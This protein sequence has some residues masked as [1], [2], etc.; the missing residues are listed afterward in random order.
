MSIVAIYGP[1]ASGKL[2]T[3]KEV[4]EHLG[5]ALFDNHAVNDVLAPIFPYTNPTLNEYRMSLSRQFRYDVFEAAL[6]S[7][8][9]MVITFNYGG[10]GGLNLCRKL[11]EL[12]TTYDEPVYFVHLV[13]KKVA[14]YE[15]VVNPS[16][17]NKANSKERLDELLQAEGY[18]YDT[19]PDVEHLQLDNTDITPTESVEK[20]KEYYR[21]DS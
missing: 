11:V 8:A 12:S 13:P 1:V 19:F 18:G 6:K 5:F 10:P 15:R 4:S 16:R 14:L 3:A 20:I 21:L 17:S 9:N 7:K 2:T